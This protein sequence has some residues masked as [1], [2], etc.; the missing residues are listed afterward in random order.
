MAPMKR[1]HH[2]ART[3][4]LAQAAR[5][6]VYVSDHCWQCP[7]A[8]ALALQMGKTFPSLKVRIVNLDEP[9][10]RKPSSVFSVP[11]FLLNGA[12]VSLG[13][14]SR[15]TLA[16]KI[17]GTLGARET[18]ANERIQDRLSALQRVVPGSER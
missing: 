4:P 10:A 5:L 14:P 18:R 17:R 3:R 1:N 9:G 7:A 12:I 16:R 11:T 13:T 2:S 8:R 15:D 6:E